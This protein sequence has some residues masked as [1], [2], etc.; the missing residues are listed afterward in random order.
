MSY[1][2]AFNT[3]LKDIAGLNLDSS[4][5]A[6]VLESV[7]NYRSVVRIE[8]D[9]L[10]G[11]IAYLGDEAK[12]LEE[13]NR[14][15]NS[16]NTALCKK[17][18]ELEAKVKSL[19][20]VKPAIKVRLNYM[21][22]KAD[23]LQE[24]FITFVKWVRSNGIDMGDGSMVG[25]YEAKFIADYVFA[26]FD[27]KAMTNGPTR[28]EQWESLDWLSSRSELEQNIIW[29]LNFNYKRSVEFVC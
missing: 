10:R 19:N 16:E 26:Y 7:L 3:L 8:H 28:G 23:S 29:L 11:T 12:N 27:Y 5:S 2:N 14:E 22:Y 6:A 24:Q 9:N 15:L 17:V 1:V 25:L 21:F 18:A 4:V 20:P 13:R